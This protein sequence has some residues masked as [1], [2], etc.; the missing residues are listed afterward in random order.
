MGK[1]IA[2]LEPENGVFVSSLDDDIK[3]K[4]VTI[5][6]RPVFIGGPGQGGGGTSGGSDDGIT[7]SDAVSSGE[8]VS[9]R[10]LG[11]GKLDSRLIGYKDDGEGVVKPMVGHGGL[12]DGNSE[13]A[14]Y[15]INKLLGGEEV[16]DTV[17]SDTFGESGTSQRFVDGATLG[18]SLTVGDIQR[19]DRLQLERAIALDVIIG[20]EDRHPGNFLM[21]GDNIIAIDHGHA[22]WRLYE[23][24]SSGTASNYLFYSAIVKDK[25]LPVSRAHFG[26]SGSKP[27]EFSESSL[28]QW[29]NITRDQFNS[30]LSNIN[31]SGNVNLDNA[32]KNLQYIVNGGDI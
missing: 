13:V 29:G 23:S 16:P 12:H 7:F 18:S 5:D 17:F 11:G 26:L 10:D 4:F 2:D 21:K 31:Q 24:T 25:S 19:A 32:W 20:N 15:E 27:F 30:A 1:S 3:G 22:S 28:S 6:G 8:I 14:A 9:M